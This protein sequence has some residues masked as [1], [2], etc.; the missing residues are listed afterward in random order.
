LA[1]CSECRDGPGVDVDE[2]L[3]PLLDG[4]AL[5]RLDVLPPKVRARS[6]T[7]NEELVGLLQDPVFTNLPRVAFDFVPPARGRVLLRR[8]PPSF[9]VSFGKIEGL[10]V[11]GKPLIPMLTR[12]ARIVDDTIDRFEVLFK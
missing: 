4:E 9:Q 12:L 3:E 10:Q 8:A 2:R 6:V 1:L 7:T 11:E 5:P